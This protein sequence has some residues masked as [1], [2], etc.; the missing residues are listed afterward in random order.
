MRVPFAYLN[1]LFL[2]ESL[3]THAGALST[4]EN[5]YWRIFHNFTGAVSHFLRVL[6]HSG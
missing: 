5:Y 4:A 1:K 6:D 3:S 2:G